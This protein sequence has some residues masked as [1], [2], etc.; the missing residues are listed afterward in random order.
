MV[1]NNDKSVA[2]KNKNILLNYSFD[3]KKTSPQRFLSSLEDDVFILLNMDLKK[4]SFCNKKVLNKEIYLAAQNKT[5][6]SFKKTIMD[7]T[8]ISHPTLMESS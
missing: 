8:K 5:K 3:Q 1:T 2:V 7:K 4:N 6:T